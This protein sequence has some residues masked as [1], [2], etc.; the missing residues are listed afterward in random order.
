VLF[1]LGI[2]ALVAV[3]VAWFAILFTGTYPRTL[4]DFVMGVIRW[5]NRVNGYAFALVTDQYPPF[6]LS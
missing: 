6:R 2:A 4:F 3:I 5:G 1:F